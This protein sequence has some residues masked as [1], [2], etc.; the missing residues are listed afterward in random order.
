MKKSRKSAKKRKTQN[1]I[2][3][4]KQVK[5]INALFRKLQFEGW[6]VKELKEE[7]APSKAKM[8]KRITKQLLKELKRIT[9]DYVRRRT[10]LKSGTGIETTW[11]QYATQRKKE[12]SERAKIRE[13]VKKA[14]K[15]QEAVYNYDEIKKSKKKYIDAEKKKGNVVEDQ[16]V[17]DTID[18]QPDDMSQVIITNFLNQCRKFP[19]YAFPIIKDFI[20][21]CVAETDAAS[22]ASMIQNAQ[23]AGYELTAEIAYDEKLLRDWMYDVLDYLDMPPITKDNLEQFV[24]EEA[25]FDTSTY[26]TVDPWA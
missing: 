22:V 8:P 24:E 15:E 21:R 4:E 25:F 23:A 16:S 17:L 13:L 9:P 19:K 1:Q 5:R 6:Q 11:K 20:E 10:I 14:R 7:I 26:T 2:E 3:Y 18:Y 12:R